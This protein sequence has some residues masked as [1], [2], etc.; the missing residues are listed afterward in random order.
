MEITEAE[1]VV[2]GSPTRE[3]NTL[4]SGWKYGINKK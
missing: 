2:P 3:G 1:M 4:A